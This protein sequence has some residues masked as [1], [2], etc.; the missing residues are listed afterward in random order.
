ML[1]ESQFSEFPQLIQDMA[2]AHGKP[3]IARHDVPAFTCGLIASGRTLANLDSLGEGPGQKVRVGRAVGYPTVVF[4]AW[5]AGRLTLEKG[6][7]HVSV[8]V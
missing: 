3:V 7:R 8:E 6:K 2:R 1:F 5:L 4:C